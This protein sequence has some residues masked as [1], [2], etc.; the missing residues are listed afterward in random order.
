MERENKIEMIV[1]KINI[2]DL[3]KREHVVK[4]L[5]AYEVVPKQTDNGVYCMVNKMSDVFVVW[6]SRA[7]N[8]LS[9]IENRVGLPAGGLS[10]MF[11]A[12]AKDPR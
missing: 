12:L 4:M 8:E 2:L 1:R 6:K 11:S 10:E 3:T 5:L 9:L 7:R